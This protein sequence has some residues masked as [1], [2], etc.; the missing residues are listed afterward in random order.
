M[1]YEAQY[2]Q[3]WAYFSHIIF[4]PDF[5]ICS[6]NMP[7]YP[8]LRTLVIA[9]LSAWEGFLYIFL[10]LPLYYN[11]GHSPLKKTFVNVGESDVWNSPTPTVVPER[12]GRGWWEKGWVQTWL[13]HE[14]AMHLWVSPLISLGP[15]VS[16]RKIDGSA[17]R[18]CPIW[19]LKNSSISRNWLWTSPSD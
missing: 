1:I 17:R 8:C 4:S 9:V 15:N 13:C 16:S 12:K 19:I 10:W 7:W 5:S 11:L 14:P 18:V 6:S 2:G 3:S